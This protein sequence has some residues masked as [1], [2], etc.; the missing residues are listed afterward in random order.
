MDYDLSKLQKT[1]SPDYALIIAT[2]VQNTGELN[3][4]EPPFHC[5]CQFS[6]LYTGILKLPGD[7]TCFFS[8]ILRTSNMIDVDAYQVLCFKLISNVEVKQEKF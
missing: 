4:E 1:F 6:K 2:H 3:N 5:A 7:T 8:T